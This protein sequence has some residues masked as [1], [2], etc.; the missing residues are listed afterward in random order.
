MLAPYSKWLL[1]FCLC[2]VAAEGSAG[3]SQDCRQPDDKELICVVTE[4]FPP[5]SYIDQ[6]GNIDGAVTRVVLALLDQLDVQ[7][8]I[9]M[10]PWARSLLIVSTEPNDLIFSLVRSP[11]HESD[12]HW[13]VPVTSIDIGVYSI[14]GS[15]HF[16]L[17]NLAD[18]TDLSVGIM[19]SS[20]SI[21]YFQ[22][23]AYVSDNNLV[24]MATF[25]QMYK[26]LM[27]GRVDLVLAPGLLMK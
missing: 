14:P 12:F 18:L 11:E 4:S 16:S 21:E 23:I 8:T 15:L 17:T 9:E 13:L 6:A 24:E 10:M 25:E 19:H 5:Y 20:S 7:T 26:M 2:W 22:S 1:C 3:S 27:S